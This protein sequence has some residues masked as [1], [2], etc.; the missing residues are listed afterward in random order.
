MAAPGRRP[1]AVIPKKVA[2]AEGNIKALNSCAAT[3][4]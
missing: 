3:R 2:A 4:F 1:H